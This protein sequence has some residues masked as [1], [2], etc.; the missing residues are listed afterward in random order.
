MGP[1]NDLQPRIREKLEAFI[2][3]HA[4]EL[5]GNNSGKGGKHGDG[6]KCGNHGRV[7]NDA[8]GNVVTATMVT[9]LAMGMEEMFMERWQ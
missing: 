3:N 8:H 4:P 6:G 2:S 7:G 9:M 1:T 5:G